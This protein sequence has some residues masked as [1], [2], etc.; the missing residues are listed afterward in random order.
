MDGYRGTQYE[1]EKENKINIPLAAVLKSVHTRY[2]A[3]NLT[4]GLNYN[5]RLRR[6]SAKFT[7]RLTSQIDKGVTEAQGGCNYRKG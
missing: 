3:R 2:T 4:D 1:I 6:N 7:M 5:D